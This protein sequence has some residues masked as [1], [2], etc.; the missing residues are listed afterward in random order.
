VRFSALALAGLA[1]GCGLSSSGAAPDAVRDA[2]RD[3][4][5]PDAGS[6]VDGSAPPVDAPYDALLPADSGVDAPPLDAGVDARVYLAG[7]ALAYD[8]SNTYVDMGGIALG[9]TTFTLEAWVFPLD[10]PREIYVAAQDKRGQGQGQFRF[11]MIATG[12]LFFAMSDGS[13]NTFGLF[14]GGSTYALLS[15]S[16]IPTSA[17]SEVAVTK[18]DTVYTLYVNGAVATSFTTQSF[19]FNDGGNPNPFRVGSRVDTD[20]TSPDGVFDGT[21]DEVRFWKTARTA[22][23]IA[24]DMGHELKSS[25]PNFGDLLHYWRFDEGS[26]TSTHDDVGGKDGTLQNGPLWVLSTAF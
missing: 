15:P 11:G 3:V 17:W 1:V 24:S 8:G 25:D 9:E 14:G 6:P 5:A 10:Y 18:A 19:V 4:G 20:G 21:I 7:E 16:P 2:G 26:G 23:E 12:Q 13:G 22:A